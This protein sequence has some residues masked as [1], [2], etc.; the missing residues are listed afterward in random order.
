MYTFLRLLFLSILS[1][2]LCLS[3]NAADIP[4]A[5]NIKPEFIPVIKKPCYIGCNYQ[6]MYCYYYNISNMN[7]AITVKEW[8]VENGFVTG[9]AVAD[10][11][12]KLLI[13]LCYQLSLTSAVPVIDE[14][15]NL[16]AEFEFKIKL[17]KDSKDQC[18]EYQENAVTYSSFELKG[19]LK[20]EPIPLMQG[21]LEQDL[22][23]IIQDS[24]SKA[25]YESLPGDKKNK[26]IYCGEDQHN[27]D[28][29]NAQCGCD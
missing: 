4:A 21:Q 9:K 18:I 26:K 12:A 14:G 3:V 19:D 29:K 1:V 25:V 8:N 2:L 11:K 27:I 15:L 22:A 13:K 16:K 23:D 24:V 10:I 6:F 7:N 5:S 20:K 28:D 17:G